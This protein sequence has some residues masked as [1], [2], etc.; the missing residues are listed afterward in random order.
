MLKERLFKFVYF[1]ES[2]DPFFVNKP[3][4]M[5]EI[6]G[7]DKGILKIKQFL[8][9]FSKGTGLFIYGPVGCGKTSSIYAFAKENNY[10]L[11]E[12][13]ASDSRNQKD[14]EDFLSRAT[15][16]MSLFA[17]KKIILI[18]EVDG[19]SGMKDR[20]A[21]KCIVEY[22]KKSNFPIIITGENIF[23]SKVSAIKKTCLCVEF[24]ELKSKDVFTIIENVLKKEKIT[25]DEKLIDKISRECAG[26]ARAALNDVFY[27]ALIN[28]SDN[29]EDEEISNRIKNSSMSDSLTRVLK[30]KDMNLVLGA[31]D[32]VEEDLDKIF[33]WL[34]ENMPKEYLQIDDVS[35]AFEELALADRF[36]NRIK[37]WQYYRFYVY[38]FE[39]LS[40]GIALAK[41][42][43][44]TIPPKYNQPT[45]ILKYWQA[46]ITYAKRKSVIEKISEKS[47]TSNKKTGKE[48]FPYIQYA[49]VND[50]KLS[51]EFDLSSEE[52]SWLKNNLIK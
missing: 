39:L 49:L 17:S 40:A 12:L 45:R 30:S 14:L 11:L 26:D 2:M 37:R 41:K 15:G 38:C 31:Y 51:E 1:F 27:Y 46:N 24:Q 10:E 44:Y 7:Q 23:D 13:N 50:K 43:K 21:A 4:G 6:I 19:L 42:T 47:H 36:F 28:K 18:D 9:N 25:L 52:I 22:I 3:K 34:D 16:Q 8:E 35:K 20:G 32:N 48:I 5:S 33:L 29:F